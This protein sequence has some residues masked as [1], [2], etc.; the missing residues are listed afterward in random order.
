MSKMF[1]RM[2]PEHRELIARQHLF[3]TASA[4]PGAGQLVA[5]GRR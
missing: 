1:P 4:A 2:L 3:F 5:E